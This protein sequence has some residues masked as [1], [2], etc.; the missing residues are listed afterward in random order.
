MCF[1]AT[2]P[3]TPHPGPSCYVLLPSGAK[4]TGQGEALRP[5]TGEAVQ[6]GMVRPARQVWTVPAALVWLQ[7]GGCSGLGLM[8]V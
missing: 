5:R 4:E 1:T 8:W 3:V 2:T 6:P 7:V